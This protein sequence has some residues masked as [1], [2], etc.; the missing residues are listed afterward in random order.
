MK[1]IVLFDVVSALGIICLCVALVAGVM[2]LIL[3]EFIT[4]VPNSNAMAPLRVIGAVGIFA[5]LACTAVLW[6]EGWV[7]LFEGWRD[8]AFGLNLL[9]LVFVLMGTVFA[10]YTLHFVRK[11]KLLRT[12][13]NENASEISEYKP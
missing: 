6:I 10:A 11:K 2:H 12:Q 9:I 7:F 3:D 4:Q 8:R 1:R 5:F 13:S